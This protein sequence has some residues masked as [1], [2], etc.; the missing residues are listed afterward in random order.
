ARFFKTRSLAVRACDL[1]RVL[2]AG[3]TAKPSR[4]VRPG[5]LLRVTTERGDF[6]IEVLALSEIRGP[7]AQAQMLYQETEA[8]QAARA[9]RAE[10]RKLL[11]PLDF[12]S[13]SRPSKKDRR[14]IN[15]LRGRTP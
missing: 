4:E 13:D 12:A 3:Q 5:D 8:S 11:G 10:E 6:E 1:G 2:S 9:Q 7:A 14:D 15:R